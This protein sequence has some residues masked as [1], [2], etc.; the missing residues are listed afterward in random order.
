MI[1]PGGRVT[2]QIAESGVHVDVAAIGV[3]Q[4]N[5]K[6]RLA[7]GALKVPFTNR[8]QDVGGSPYLVEKRETGF[9]SSRFDRR[10]YTLGYCP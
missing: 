6:A 5:A 10:S 7:E 9:F 8:K 3:D 2:D 1:N 4:G